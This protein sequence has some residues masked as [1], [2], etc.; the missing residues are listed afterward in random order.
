MFNLLRAGFV[1]ICLLALVGCGKKTET[2]VGTPGADG[3]SCY[4]DKREDGNYVVCGDSEFRVADGQDGA[5]G[6][7]GV[8]GTNGTDGEDG[9]DGSFDGY[10]EYVTV[11]PE[12]N[13]SYKEVLVE[14]DGQFLAFL[15]DGNYKKQRLVVLEEGVMYKTTDGRNVSFSIVSGELVCL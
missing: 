12:V 11:C 8:D 15:S 6:K 3:E 2:I 10:L 4:A 7:D 14:L 9:K 5:D 1:A 13:G